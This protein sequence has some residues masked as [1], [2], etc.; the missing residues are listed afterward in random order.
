MAEA[1]P[2]ILQPWLYE[3]VNNF[4]HLNHSH[5]LWKL[6]IENVLSSTF[7]TMF[8]RSIYFLMI[9][10]YCI[11]IEFYI[12]YKLLANL[13][14]YNLTIKSLKKNSFGS[15]N[16]L[17]C[18]KYLTSQFELC[19]TFK[20]FPASERNSFALIITRN[21][22]H[23]LISTQIIQYCFNQHRFNYVS[24]GKAINHCFTKYIYIN[25]SIFYR[26]MFHYSRLR[27]LQ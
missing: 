20:K 22:L 4:S 21:K 10:Y 13:Y 15:H 1:F 5:V 24:M 7:C 3:F 23:V 9:Y 27:T 2:V 25:F 6:L 17:R 12:R 8:K 26:I 11:C 18:I 14:N 19:N 16:K